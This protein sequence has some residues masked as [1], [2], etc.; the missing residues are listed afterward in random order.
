MVVIICLVI[1]LC[2]CRINSTHTWSPSFKKLLIGAVA[3]GLTEGA[4]L[5]E[6]IVE[7]DWV[8]L[9]LVATEEALALQDDGLV[10]LDV[11]ENS[12]HGERGSRLNQWAGFS[13]RVLESWSLF[14]GSSCCWLPTW[15]GL[16]KVLTSDLISWF[17]LVDRLLG[18]IIE[19]FVGNW[20]T[21]EMTSWGS[22]LDFFATSSSSLSLEKEL[23]FCRNR[24]KEPFSCCGSRQE[25][26]CL[27]CGSSQ[28]FS[29]GTSVGSSFTEMHW[30]LCDL[31]DSCW[32]PCGSGQKKKKDKTP[33]VVSLHTYRSTIVSVLS[34]IKKIPV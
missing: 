9:L 11:K 15:T 14:T 20:G 6:E 23:G 34:L 21:V 25:F 33:V 24:L 18:N 30:T 5:P 26:S 32:T 29:A 16:R 12:S 8:M 22:L 2:E 7:V 28:G 13:A 1:C 4:M 27:A 17:K 31:S 19:V 10:E 3:E